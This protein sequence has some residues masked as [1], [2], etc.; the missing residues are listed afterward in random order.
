MPFGPGPITRL[1]NRHLPDHHVLASYP[2]HSIVRLT[3]PPENQTFRKQVG[4]AP[5][6]PVL[7]CR[8]SPSDIQ[9]RHSSTSPRFPDDDVPDRRAPF[10]PRQARR[11]MSLSSWS[12]PDG[13]P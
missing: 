12:P 1:T 3:T 11:R 10:Q 8:L 6:H 9:A 13:H 4:P 7:L 2:P 5:L